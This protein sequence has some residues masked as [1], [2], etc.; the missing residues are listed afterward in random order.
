MRISDCTSSH[1]GTAFSSGVRDP[2]RETSENRNVIWLLSTL[3]KL[4]VE[5]LDMILKIQTYVSRFDL[6]SEW[7][8]D[9]A[10]KRG[11]GMTL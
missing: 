11:S 4:T 5:W 9:T 3:E 1:S 2:F 8:P 7:I 10:E 6:S